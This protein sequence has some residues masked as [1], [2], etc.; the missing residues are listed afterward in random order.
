MGVQ[1]L[2]ITVALCLGYGGMRFLV[3]TISLENLLLNCVALEFILSL[4][5]AIFVSF[6]PRKVRPTV[7]QCRVDAEWAVAARTLVDALDVEAPTTQC[8][9]CH[10]CSLQN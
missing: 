1:A 3:A 9:G 8:S 10:A 2:R 4:D 5:D 7:G 6:G